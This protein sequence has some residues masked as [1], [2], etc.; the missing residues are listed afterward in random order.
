MI[1]WGTP[2]A[3]AIHWRMSD[4]E[5]RKRGER[6]GLD[7]DAELCGTNAENRGNVSFRSDAELKIWLY[8]GK[9]KYLQILV[10]SESEGRVTN[11][12]VW[13]ISREEFGGIMSQN[14][15]S[16]VGYCGN[17]KCTIIQQ[18]KHECVDP[19]CPNKDKGQHFHCKK[20]GELL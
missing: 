7:E 20:C 14:I 13:T 11:L 1:S 17:P 12:E 2:K 18:A 4:A 6:T 16:E 19:N 8:A 10:P 9:S 3:K 5:T 15:V